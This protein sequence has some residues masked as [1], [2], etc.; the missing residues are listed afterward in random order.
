[1][2]SKRGTVG[3]DGKT[4]RIDGGKNASKRAKGG[5]PSRWG[6]GDRS[7]V[8]FRD[9]AGVRTEATGKQA[10]VYFVVKGALGE[11]G[12]EAVKGA[13]PN[14]GEAECVNLYAYDTRGEGPEP[15]LVAVLSREDRPDWKAQASQNLGEMTARVSARPLPRFRVKA[16]PDRI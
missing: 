4:V 14:G 7:K 5:Q 16:Q 1:M 10:R 9:C 6:S 13:C 8:L 15:R 2:A 11:G 3:R 12:K